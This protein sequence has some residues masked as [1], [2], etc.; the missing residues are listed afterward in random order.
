MHNEAVAGSTAARLINRLLRGEM[1]ESAPL[2]EVAEMLSASPL[3]V[4]D[5]ELKQVAVAALAQYVAAGVLIFVD[6]GK[7]KPH[8]LL[9]PLIILDRPSTWK[10]TVHQEKIFV[11]LPSALAKLKPMLVAGGLWP[12]LADQWCGIKVDAACEVQGRP[13]EAG[14]AP[15]IESIF[16]TKELKIHLVGVGRVVGENGREIKWQSLIGK[17]DLIESARVGVTQPGRAATWNIEKV[18]EFL[19]RHGYKCEHRAIHSPTPTKQGASAIPTANT[20]FPIR[21]ANPAS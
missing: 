13:V 8:L 14:L 11:I 7:T 9:P 16:T 15:K 10:S 12:A 1:P 20:P 21:E 3:G 4:P 18:H 5:A 19:Q 17:L 2:G 6:S